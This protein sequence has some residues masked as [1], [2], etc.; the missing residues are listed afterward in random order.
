MFSGKRGKYSASHEFQYTVPQGIKK[1]YWLVEVW[2]GSDIA[3]GTFPQ[4]I[5]P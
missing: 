4:T 5:S 3:T 2:D 1:I